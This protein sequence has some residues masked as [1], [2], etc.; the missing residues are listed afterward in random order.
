MHEVSE[1]HEVSS[2]VC[3]CRAHACSGTR[4]TMDRRDGSGWSD[5]GSAMC[6]VTRMCSAPS[7]MASLSCSAVATTV[8]AAAAA[9]RCAQQ[10]ASAASAAPRAA[11]QVFLDVGKV[12]SSAPAQTS[13]VRSSGGWSGC[14]PVYA[15]SVA[16]LPH[17]TLLCYQV[18][19]SYYICTKGL[20]RIVFVVRRCEQSK[21]AGLAC[22]RH[23]RG[24]VRTCAGLS[25]RSR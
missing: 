10:T 23:A 8:T 22:K 20:G 6:S 17:A 13:F 12:R 19:S 9:C 25:M 11:I 5:L 4:T 2:S 15:C 14:W 21:S 16:E 1:V 24:F 3:C 7:S 18:R